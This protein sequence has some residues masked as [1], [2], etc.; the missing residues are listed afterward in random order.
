M[1]TLCNAVNFLQE[2]FN[3]NYPSRQ[4]KMKLLARR[5]GNFYHATMLAPSEAALSALVHITPGF[6]LTVSW[7]AQV[8]PVNEEIAR[9]LEP[10]A[11]GRLAECP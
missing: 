5:G 8:A 3:R 11:R 1:S 4:G 7:L 2:G 6:G 10:S 9:S